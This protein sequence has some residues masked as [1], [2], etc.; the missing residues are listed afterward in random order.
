[1]KRQGEIKFYCNWLFNI[2][3]WLGCLL[4]VAAPFEV[5]GAT[6]ALKPGE[7][8]ESVDGFCWGLNGL[9]EL[10]DISSQLL[11]RKFPTLGPIRVSCFVNKKSL[12]T[13]GFYL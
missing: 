4:I 9:D 1:M 10:G 13:D 12:L 3:I 7:G 2:Y 11:N 8:I 5:V 6:D